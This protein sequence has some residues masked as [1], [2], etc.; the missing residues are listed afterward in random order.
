RA[1]EAGLREEAGQGRVLDVVVE[2]FVVGRFGEVGAVDVHQHAHRR[3]R[4][5][6]VHVPLRVGHGFEH[7]HGFEEEVGFVGLEHAEGGGAGGRVDEQVDTVAHQ[8]VVGGEEA[9]VL[10]HDGLGAG[11]G[12]EHAV[13]GG[14]GKTFDVG[15]AGVEVEFAVFEV[16]D[17]HA[18]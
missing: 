18:V 1:V 6:L 11:G 12:G 7:K 3:G 8:R 17:G 2:V 5:E 4:E 14:G 13:A 9:H 15:M 10:A 16:L